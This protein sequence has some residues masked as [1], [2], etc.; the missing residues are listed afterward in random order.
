MPAISFS[1]R[2]VRM[3]EIGRKKQTIRKMRKRPFKVGDKLYL[4]SQQR[5]PRHSRKIGEAVVTYVQDIRILIPERIIILGGSGGLMNE[6][7]L[8]LARA[9]GF[10]NLDDFFR[11]FESY[12]LKDDGEFFGQIIMWGEIVDKIEDNPKPVSIPA[13][14]KYIKALESIIETL[15]TEK[16]HSAAELRELLDGLHEG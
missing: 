1:Q 16:G 2:F 15:Y 8:Y 5:S 6:E 3:V 10:A 14:Q 4:Y 12:T 9:D 13:L 11:F 7:A